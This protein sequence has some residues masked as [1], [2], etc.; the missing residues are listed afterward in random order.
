MTAK[1]TK[2]VLSVALVGLLVS[3]IGCD[4]D[5]RGRGGSYTDVLVGFD[6]WP[7]SWSWGG[8]DEYTTYDSYEET[9]YD[10]SYYEEYSDYGYYDGGSYDGG[11][12]DNG[13]YWDDWKTKRRG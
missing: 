4:K 5:G 8:Y 12:Y 6:W 10:S 9:Y 2:I 11:Y 3:A 13:G 7:S 1:L